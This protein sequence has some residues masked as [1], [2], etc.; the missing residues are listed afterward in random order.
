MHYKVHLSHL[1]SSCRCAGKEREWTEERGERRG[2]ERGEV[3]GGKREKGN[4]L[5]IP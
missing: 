3:M 2:K 4:R 5:K 1:P